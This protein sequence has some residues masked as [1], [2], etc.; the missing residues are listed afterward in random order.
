MVYD[1]E[2]VLVYVQRFFKNIQIFHCIC[3]IYR[4]AG[5]ESLN[6]YRLVEAWSA[7]AG[8]AFGLYVL[9]ESLELLLSTALS[10]LGRKPLR[11][12]GLDCVWYFRPDGVAGSLYTDTVASSAVWDGR[13]NRLFLKIMFPALY[14][15]KLL[16]EVSTVFLIN[17][18]ILVF[19]DRPYLNTY[20]MYRAGCR[21]FSL[22][23]EN[24]LQGE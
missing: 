24:H 20:T 18:I 3:Y 1:S 11:L 19:R 16:G 6:L 21:R 4:P 23:R 5:L 10:L 14:I 2:L 9:R 8:E 7:W 22:V 15:N 17:I 12:A 13:P